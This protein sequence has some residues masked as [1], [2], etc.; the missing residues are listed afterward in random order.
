VF[1]FPRKGFACL[2]EGFFATLSQEQAVGL[3]VE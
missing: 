2:H 1:T 3:D